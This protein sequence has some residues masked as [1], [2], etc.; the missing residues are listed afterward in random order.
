MK[1]LRSIIAIIAAS[2]CG[3]AAL[4]AGSALA[5]DVNA[6]GKSSGAVD[7]AVVPAAAQADK[8]WGMLDKYCV[9]CHNFEDWKGGIAFDT[10]LPDSVP[11]DAKTW[12]KALERLRGRLMPPPGKPL[13][14]EA[15]REGLSRRG[16]RQASRSRLCRAA[17]VEP[18]GIC[19]RDP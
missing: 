6:G 5:A 8:H 1:H 18:E 2:M 14:D 11:Q 17:P 10:M 13:P 4:L 3:A 19:Q 12:E 16:R 15:T 7:A 9:E